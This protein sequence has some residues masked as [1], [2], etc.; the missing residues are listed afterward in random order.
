M[1]PSATNT[2]MVVAIWGHHTW[3]ALSLETYVVWVTIATL[4]Q[5]SITWVNREA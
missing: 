4:L 3:V 5:L 2:G 1:M